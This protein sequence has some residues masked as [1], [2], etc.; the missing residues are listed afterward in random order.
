MLMLML[1]IKPLSFICLGARDLLVDSEEQD[2]SN[3]N[4]NPNPNCYLD[5][6]E[7]G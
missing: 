7:Q 2:Y 4:P 6:E 5:S 1:I 3:P